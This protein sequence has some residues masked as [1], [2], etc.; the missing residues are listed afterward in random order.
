MANK[1]QAT[2]GRKISRA[3]SRR[4]LLQA[5]GATGV[6]AAALAAGTAGAAA[7]PPNAKDRG[8]AGYRETAHVKAYYAAL[9]RF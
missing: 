6:A 9:T 8:T 3:L 4:G 5:A 1:D 7:T 2:T